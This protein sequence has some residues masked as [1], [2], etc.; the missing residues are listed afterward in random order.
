VKKGGGRERSKKEGKNGEGGRGG[1]GE[2][3]HWLEFQA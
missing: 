2:T 1:E 3:Y